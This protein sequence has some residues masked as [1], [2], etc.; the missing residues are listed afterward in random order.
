MRNNVG[1][2]YSS[3]V[4]STQWYNAAVAYPQVTVGRGGWTTRSGNTGD[5]QRQHVVTLY[6]DTWI[7]ATRAPASSMFGATGYKHSLQLLDQEVKR[8]ID[9][10]NK[11]PSSKLVHMMITNSVPLDEITDARK[12]FRTRHSVRV[13]WSETIA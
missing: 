3:T 13:F 11:A 1:S 4:F 9:S 8:I 5:T 6:V 2:T 12:V 7:T 10:Q